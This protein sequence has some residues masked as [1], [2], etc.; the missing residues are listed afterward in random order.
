MRIIKARRRYLKEILEI[1]NEC[2]KNAFK[3]E[4]ILYEM[5]ENPFSHFLLAKEKGEIVGFIIFW[6]TFETSTICQIAVKKACRNQGFATKLLERSEV[7]LKKNDVEF[8]SLEVRE[9]N[10]A[11]RKLYEK[12]GFTT[13]TKKEKYYNDGEDALYMMKG[14]I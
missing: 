4:N 2:F 11:A 5:E 10:V 14:E 13:I 8:Y 1:E 12:F 6:I 9:S 3:E 7:I